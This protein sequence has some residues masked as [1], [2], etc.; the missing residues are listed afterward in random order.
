MLSDL[1]VAG[2]LATDPFAAKTLELFE[3]LAIADSGNERILP[4]SW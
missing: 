2:E 4:F 1:N 3:E